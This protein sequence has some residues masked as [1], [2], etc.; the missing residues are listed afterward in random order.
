MIEIFSRFENKYLLTEEK[1]HA[2]KDAL[3]EHMDADGYNKSSSF[4]S[5]KNLYLDT[6]DSFLIRTSMQKPIYKEK[7]RL[8]G[9][10]ELEADDLVFLE[11]KK[12]YK[13]LVSKRRTALTLS[14][15]ERYI[16]TGLKPGPSSHINNQIL[17][18]IDY[19][20]RSLALAPALYL[21]YD[22]MA[23][24]E[25]EDTDLRVTFDKNIRTRRT[26][27]RLASSP[28]DTALLEDGVYLMEIKTANGI[29]LWLTQLLSEKG[30]YSDSFSKYGAEY[31]RLLEY[32][33]HKGEN[34]QCSSQSSPLKP[35]H[36]YTLTP[37][38]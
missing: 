13:G 35:T 24:F 17:S 20:M 32:N 14:E 27:L 23:Y 5:I 37:R 33:Y 16:K 36:L 12:K 30:I 21:S 8:R 15:A 29:P 6:P 10:G 1:F 9:Y 2:V 22:R 4:Y 28:E 34:E 25:R 3:A 11:I 18:E 19:M 38:L 7:L 26:D 31:Q